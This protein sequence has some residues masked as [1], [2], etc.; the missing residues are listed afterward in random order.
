MNVHKFYAGHKIIALK[1]IKADF[2]NSGINQ[3]HRWKKML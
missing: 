1:I 3:I 2:S